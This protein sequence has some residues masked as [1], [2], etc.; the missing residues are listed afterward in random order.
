MF[1]IFV[2][3]VGNF[4]FQATRSEFKALPRTT[5]YEPVFISNSTPHP[6]T[7]KFKDERDEA[8]REARTVKPATRARELLSEGYDPQR[9]RQVLSGGKSKGADK[10]ASA[11]QQSATAMDDLRRE[12]AKTEALAKERDELRR[13]LHAAG[14]RV[15]GTTAVGEARAV[16]LQFLC[17]F[18]LILRPSNLGSC[19]IISSD[20]RWSSCLGR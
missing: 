8:K 9:A 20:Q 16:E 11:Q 19:L 2:S 14:G 17:N 10:S 13:L 6:P 1:V 3:L 7:Q 15:P 12:R 4:Q 18:S 5:K